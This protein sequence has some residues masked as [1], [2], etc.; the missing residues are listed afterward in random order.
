MRV[1]YVQM[2]PR[3]GQVDANVATA[4][5]LIRQARADLLVLPELFNTGYLFTGRE[6]SE[7]FAEPVPQGPTVRALAAA[8]RE[9]NTILVAGLAER[10]DR[11]GGA[12]A[13]YN[14][15]ALITPA[16]WQATYRKAHLF[17]DE[18]TWFDPG[19]TPLRAYD[20]GSI[21]VGIMICFD[22]IF[23]ETA[24]LLALAGADVICHPSNL[25]LPY[26]PDA[27]VTRCIENR[28][29]AVTANRIG[30]ETR[31]GATLTYI[32]NSEVVSPAGEILLRAGAEGEEAGVVDIDPAAARNKTIL[33]R[34]HLFGD[35]RLDLYGP[36]LE[37]SGQETLLDHPKS[38]QLSGDAMSAQGHA[39]GQN[40]KES[41]P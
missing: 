19:D 12:P 11:P 20:L 40:R 29:F 6:E 1:G 38:I 2:N 3:F 17:H 27:M 28:V 24:R 25:V 39:P 32:G 41:T 35:R 37:P 7:T 5:N 23:P 9:T 36:L 10:V 26:C 33:D 15:A 8:A 18:K 34:N 21:R 4:I 14:A 30:R 16:G 13:V 22:W 31:G